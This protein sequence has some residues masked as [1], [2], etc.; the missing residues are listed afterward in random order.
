MREFG[1]ALPS[2]AEVV[3]TLLES[4]TSEFTDFNQ[5]SESGHFLAFERG[6]E[7]GTTHSLLSDQNFRPAFVQL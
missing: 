7:T 4:A 5:I 6:D 3:S 2:R 1:P